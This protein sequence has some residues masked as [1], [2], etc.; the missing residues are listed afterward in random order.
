MAY[1]EV[2][3]R[4]S[5]GKGGPH[6]RRRIHISERLPDL[7]H[8]DAEFIRNA[9]EILPEPLSLDLSAA[10]ANKC[11]YDPVLEHAHGTR[12]LSG[13]WSVRGQS[14]GLGRFGMDPNCDDGVPLTHVPSK[15]KQAVG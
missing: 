6:E 12:Q 9:F 5:Y 15:A 4:A 11:P 3:P 7:I 14:H 13:R 1:G 8:A 2:S 10:P